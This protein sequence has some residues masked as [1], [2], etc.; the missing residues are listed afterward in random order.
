MDVIHRVDDYT[1]ERV[2]VDVHPEAVN[3]EYCKRYVTTYQGRWR[4]LGTLRKQDSA[5][6]VQALK[7]KAKKQAKRADCTKG[8]NKKPRLSEQTEPAAPV[9]LSDIQAL[10]E[11][12]F[13]ANHDNAPVTAPFTSVGSN[14]TGLIDKACEEAPDPSTGRIRAGGEEAHS[15]SSTAAASEDPRRRYRTGDPEREIQGEVL[16]CIRCLPMLVTASYCWDQ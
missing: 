1:D 9:V 4:N 16:T 8:P 3:R 15:S 11:R 12:E 13:G 6:G 5:A 14:L 10:V 7:P 2:P